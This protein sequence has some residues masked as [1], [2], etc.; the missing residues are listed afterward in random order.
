MS[1]MGCMTKKQIQL[2]AAEV[3]KEFPGWTMEFSIA[4]PDFC[5]RESKVIYIYRDCINAY[6]W[7]AKERVLHE[8]AHIETEEDCFHSG[9]FYREYIRLLF[10]HMLGDAVIIVDAPGK[11]RVSNESM[12]G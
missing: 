6:P 3:L 12:R 4:A 8:A 9:L 7:Q 10:R 2:F 5:A 1:N 11:E